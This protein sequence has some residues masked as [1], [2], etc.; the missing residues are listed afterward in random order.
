MLLCHLQADAPGVN[1]PGHGPTVAQ[2]PWARH[3]AANTNTTRTSDDADGNKVSVTDGA[4]E[5]PSYGYD[6]DNELTTITNPNQ[7]SASFGY[8]PDGHETSSTDENGHTWRDT[9]DA[10][11]RLASS[12]DPLGDTTTYGHDPAGRTTSVTNA[13]GETT[14]FTYDAH[15]ERTAE[16][17]ADTAILTYDQAGELSSYTASATYG[18]EYNGDGL[19][20]SKFAGTPAGGVR[21]GTFIWDTEAT[22]PRILAHLARTFVYGPNGLPVEQMTLTTTDFRPRAPEPARRSPGRCAAAGRGAAGCRRRSRGHVAHRWGGPGKRDRR[23]PRASP[24]GPGGA[25]WMNPGIAG[26]R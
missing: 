15:G 23:H 22:N 13:S 10:L 17:G 16:T 4:G 26:T 21:A 18:Y 5:T 7:T 6:A 25:A 9:D 20:M 14:S 3:D 11:G 8:N 19:R 1:C 12:T 2:V 24:G